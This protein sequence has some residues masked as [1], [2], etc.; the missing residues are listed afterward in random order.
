MTNQ[1]PR[2]IPSDA[3][4]A[5]TVEALRH[6]FGSAAVSPGEALRALPGSQAQDPASAARQRRHRG[7][8][9]FPIREIGQ[10]RAVLISDIAL[11]MLGLSVADAAEPK[12]HKRPGRPRK[13]KSQRAGGAK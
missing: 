8:Y 10:Q 7:T 2:T 9:P 13:S 5:A 12:A 1:T 3:A 4:Y 11:V 6:Q